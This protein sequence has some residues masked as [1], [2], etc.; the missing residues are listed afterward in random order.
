MPASTWYISGHLQKKPHC[1]GQ[2][3]LPI[4]FTDIPPGRSFYIPHPSTK[5]KMMFK[6]AILPLLFMLAGYAVGAPITKRCS[7]TNINGK[8][9][10]DNSGG[11]E[12]EASANGVTAVSGTGN[13]AN[14]ANAG[15][16]DGGDLADAFKNAFGAPFTKRCSVTNINGKV[17]VDNSGGGDCEASANGVTAVSGNGAGALD[18]GDFADAFKNAFGN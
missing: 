12:C 1:I 13:A 9:T 3:F 6:P 2:P 14:A 8:V 18:G 17:T 10:V 5:H 11:G 15:T 16:I 7:V 4:A